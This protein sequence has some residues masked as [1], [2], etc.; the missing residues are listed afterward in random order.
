MLVQV[1]KAWK[2]ALGKKGKLSATALVLTAEEAGGWLE[3][4]G[5]R[6]TLP[7]GS[8]VAWPILPHDQYKKDGSAALALAKLVLTL[9]LTAVQ[10]RLAVTITRLSP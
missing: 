6:I 5:W 8:R 3:H 4:A 2:S 1:S 7:A 10:P 9:P